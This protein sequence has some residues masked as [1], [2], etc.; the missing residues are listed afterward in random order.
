[1]AADAAADAA[2]VEDKRTIMTNDRFGLTWHPALAADIVRARGQVDT[3]EVIPEVALRAARG[4]R[5]FLRILSRQIPVSL[6]GVSLGLASA[7]AVEEWRLDEMARLVEEVQPEDWSEHLAFVRAGGIELGHLAAPPRTTSVIEGLMANL[8]RARSIV[9]MA[10][11]LE[12]VAT[13]LDPP[14]STCDEQT[15]LCDVLAATGAP[16]LLDL[17]NVCTN[18]VNLHYDARAFVRALPL[19]RIS[20]VHIAGGTDAVDTATGVTLRVDDH[21]HDVPAE[22]FELLTLV[23][24]LAPQPL[25]IV[26]ERDGDFPP[27]E[28]LLHELELARTALAAGRGALSRGSS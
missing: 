26:L 20:T 6:H 12:N 24:A 4:D 7:C 16:L 5:D 14:G 3:L 2:A 18:A 27:F 11:A 22:V 28:Q 9:G 21:R 1:V 23:G 17:H 15:W 19:E 25:T 13:I 8:R 10:P